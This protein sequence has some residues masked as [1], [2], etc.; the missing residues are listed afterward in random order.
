MQVNETKILEHI[1]FIFVLPIALLYFNIINKDFRVLVLAVACL[2]IYG[3][4]KKDHWSKK[5]MAMV[6]GDRKSHLVPYAF[7]MLVGTFVI[8]LLARLFG[9]EPETSW[10]SSREFWANP[11]FL[12]LFVVVSFLQEFAYRVFLIRELE[13]IFSKTSTVIVINAILFIFLHAIY[14]LTWPSV[15]LVTI[16]S[17]AFPLMYIKY[18]DFWLIGLAHSLFNFIAVLHGFLVISS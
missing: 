1:A 13:G 3:I 9:L 18:R 10:W 16:S 6:V 8:L 17:V 7:F 12:F 5:D 2:L 11:H 4:I 15:I 14:P